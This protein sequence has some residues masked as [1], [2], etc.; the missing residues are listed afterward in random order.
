MRVSNYNYSKAS[1]RGRELC[2]HLPTTTHPHNLMSWW[3]VCVQP[4][5][6]LQ[7]KWL[8]VFRCILFLLLDTTFGRE[9]VSLLLVVATT[10][11]MACLVRV[12]CSSGMECKHVMRCDD[13]HTRSKLYLTYVLNYWSQVVMV[14]CDGHDTSSFM[15]HP[16]SWHILVHDTSS[17][18]HRAWSLPLEDV[19]RCELR[20]SYCMCHSVLSYPSLPMATEMF[21]TALEQ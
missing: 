15:T 19:F 10:C 5:G 1:W 2:F 3:M 21:H 12:A 13:D 17:H 8:D 11:W 9:T 14:V 6:A 16:R 7:R 20:S 18:P 4:V